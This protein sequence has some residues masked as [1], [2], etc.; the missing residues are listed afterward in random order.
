MIINGEDINL[1]HEINVNGEINTKTKK[2]MFIVEITEKRDPKLNL[3]IAVG[4]DDPYMHI[5]TI[6]HKNEDI[7]SYVSEEFMDYI[8]K[9]VEKSALENAKAQFLA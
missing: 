1:V 4:Y 8:Y 3:K 7:T 6:M 5:V 2:G 9:H